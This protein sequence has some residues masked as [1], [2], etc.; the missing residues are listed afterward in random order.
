MQ[1]FSMSALSMASQ[2]VTALL[3]VSGQ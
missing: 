2:Q 3:G 1:A